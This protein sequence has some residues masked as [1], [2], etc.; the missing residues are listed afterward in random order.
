MVDFNKLRIDQEK[1]KKWDSDQIRDWILPVL[2]P[3]EIFNI[4]HIKP[5]VSLSPCLYF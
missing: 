5:K 1:T 2:L 3:S 4:I